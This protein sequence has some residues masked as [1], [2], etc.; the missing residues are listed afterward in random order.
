MVHLCLQFAKKYPNF[1]PAQ[2]YLGQHKSYL[3]LPK[4]ANVHSISPA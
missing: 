1:N 2:K 3:T 4:D